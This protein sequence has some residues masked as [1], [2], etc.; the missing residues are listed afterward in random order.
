MRTTFISLIALLFCVVQSVAQDKISGRILDLSEKIPLKNASVMLLQAQDSILVGYTRADEKGDFS[1]NKPKSGNFLVV[2]SYPKY[3]DFFKEIKETE[4]ESDLGEVLL[5]SVAHLIE[6]VVVKRRAAITIKGDT[7]EYDASQFKM[8]K[9]AK[10]ED[11]LKVLPGITVDASGNITAQG[12]TV[13]KVLVDGEEFFGDDPTL[14]TRNI[15]SDMVDKVQVYE[16]MSDQAERTGVDDGVREQTINLKLKEDAKNGIFGKALAGGGTDGYYMGQLMFNKFKGSQKISAYGLLGNNATTSMN[17]EDA[18][19]YGGDSGSTVSDEGITFVESQVDPFS[20][21]GVVGIPR[22]INSGIN[23]N[24]KF[25]GDKHTVNLSYKYGNIK[26]DGVDETLM[27][28][29]INS[30]TRKM[31]DTKNDQHRVNLR[32]DLKLDSLNSILLRGNVS[33]KNLWSEDQTNSKNFGNDLS[34]PVAEN[35]S[36]Q[37]SD[38]EINNYGAYLLY[39]KKFM[40][41][42]R[43]ISLNAEVKREENTGGGTLYSTLSRANAADTI[44]DQYKNHNQKV[45]N[46]IAGVTYTEP[47]TKKLNLSVGYNVEKVDN[48]SLMESFNTQGNMLDSTFSNNYDYN[49]LSQNVSVGLNYAGES[50]KVRFNN[51]LSDDALDQ[52]NNYTSATLKRSFFTYNP[53]ITG[54]WAITK[55]K[56]MWFQ[57][58]GKNQLPSLS[59]IQ[60]LRNNNDPLNFYEGNESLK[61]SFNNSGSLGYYSFQALSGTYLYIGGNVSFVN[62]PIS[63]NITNEN[64]VNYYRWANIDG[65]TDKTFSGWAGRY[66]KLSNK[67]GLTNTIQLTLFNSQYNNFFNGQENLIKSDSYSFSYDIG[68]DTK[69][70]LNF[71]ISLNPQYR[72]MT[73]NLSPDQDN[74]GFV[75][76][77]SGKVE[78]FFPKGFKIYTN[79]SYTYEA[80]TDAFD[81]S[82]SRLLIDPGVSKKFLKDESLVL[83]LAVYDLLN[84]NVGYSR[85]QSNSV[86]MQRRYDTIRRYVM[87]KLSWDFNKM[88]IK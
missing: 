76:K 81:Q 83:D 52:T 25:N 47:L 30:E 79:Y 82:L 74:S 57:Y 53:M 6:E 27:S 20:G 80:P 13:K 69:T 36:R 55:S 14:A 66:F 59:Q 4:P 18:Q 49:R 16:K 32:Y 61:P 31:V 42:G 46:L 54:S 5:T 64:G 51:I 1:L 71:N 67:L 75:F 3:A 29:I 10:V 24:D 21:Q 58:S 39:T 28:G 86:F 23:Y 84:Q 85:S 63:Q 62:D 26:S 9:N 60:P 70:G 7:T 45:N 68:R 41:K 65:K 2:V 37:V 12:K 43:S 72:K 87:L 78:Y 19:K 33:R 38:S 17:W 34:S 50:L 56:H 8:E 15:R 35:V 11:L 48:T 73:S 77:S 40:K 22:A 44:T 88:F